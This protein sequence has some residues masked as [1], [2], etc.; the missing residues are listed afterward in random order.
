MIRHPALAA[1][2]RDVPMLLFLEESGDCVG[3]TGLHRI[4]E[5]AGFTLEGSMR[6]ERA[7]PHGEL[8]DTCLCAITP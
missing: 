8:R 5:R 6:H 7:T 2:R 3:A 4:A 1:L